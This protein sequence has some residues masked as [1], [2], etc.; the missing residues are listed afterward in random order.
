MTDGMEG[1]A[2]VAIIGA[3]GAL[4]SAL[5]GVLLTQLY[6]MLR[7]RSGE[8][9]WYAEFFLGRKIDAISDLY[10]ALIDYFLAIDRNLASPPASLSAYY[11]HCDSKKQA[12]WRAMAMAT[13][14]LDSET[15]DA[16]IRAASAFDQASTAILLGLPDDEC[17][18]DKGSYDASASI[19]NR[20]ELVDAHGEAAERLREML[21]PAVLREV[22]ER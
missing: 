2:V 19:V 9:R 4:I 3:V 11:E 10:A 12:Y 7:A 6:E 1:V 14:Y 17:P 21:D 16:V 20:S 15:R 5:V 13:I 22:R 18:L 8:R